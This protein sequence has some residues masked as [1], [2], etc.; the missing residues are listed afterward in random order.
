NV[1]GID[2]SQ[3]MV[4]AAQQKYPTIEFS[5]LDAAKM[6]FTNQF[7]A[8]FSNA[9]LHWMK[10]Q[11]QV[12]KNIYNALKT[13]GRFVA[14]M[15]GHGNIASI[16]GAVKKSMATLNYTYSE[17]DFPWYFPTINEY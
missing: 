14:E 4:R 2:A 13:N 16:V 11:D 6:Q 10:Q 12:V 5:T 9:A 15:G 7:D 1:Q 3:E 8:V 17:D